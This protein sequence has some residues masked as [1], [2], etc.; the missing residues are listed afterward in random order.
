MFILH[1]RK[2]E[3]ISIDLN[4]LSHNTITMIYH[5]FLLGLG[6]SG[7]DDEALLALLVPTDCRLARIASMGHMHYVMMLGFKIQNSLCLFKC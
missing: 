3:I 5:G 1:V 6:A 2:K 7:G 4:R